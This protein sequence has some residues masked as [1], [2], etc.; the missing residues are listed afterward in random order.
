[1]ARSETPVPASTPTVSPMPIMQTD[2]IAAKPVQSVVSDSTIQN[3][4]QIKYDLKKTAIVIAVLAL[5]I[6]ALVL[7]DQKYNILLS[8]GDILFRV[9][10]IQ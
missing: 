4:P 1:M 9:L 6:V 2:V 3:L 7:L 8:F 10:H 5:I